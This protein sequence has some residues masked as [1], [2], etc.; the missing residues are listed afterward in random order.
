MK[1]NSEINAP[2]YLELVCKKGIETDK[3][4]DE[5]TDL[6]SSYL[7]PDCF[8]LQGIVDSLIDNEK[9][10]VIFS[11]D[12]LPNMPKGEDAL[13]FIKAVFETFFNYYP[14]YTEPI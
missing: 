5:L 9:C 14:K 8:S 3:I 13:G 6:A 12:I 1:I 7:I 4:I 11:V 2:V 10:V